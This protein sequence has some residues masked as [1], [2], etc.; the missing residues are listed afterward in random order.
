[1]IVLALDPGKVTGMAWISSFGLASVSFHALELPAMD[2]VRTMED[3]LVRQEFSKCLLVAEIYTVTSNTVRHSRQY[4][5]LEVIG[6]ARY[7]A[8]KY[9]WDFHMQTPA[10]RKIIKDSAL[11]KLDWYKPSKDKHMIDA[12]KHLGVACLRE[13]ILDPKD[14]L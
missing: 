4:D 14:L 5:A 11:K 13:K 8:Q 9:A 12:A 6:C 1:M 3:I 10:S 7:L 2:A